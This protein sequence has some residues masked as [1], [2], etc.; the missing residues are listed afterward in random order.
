MSTHPAGTLTAVD[1]DRT[2]IY[3]AAALGLDL[4]DA[5]APRLMCVEVYRGAPLS[6]VTERAADLLSRLAE[7]TLLVP[8]TT[9]TPEQFARVHL[10][11]L[12]PEPTRGPGVAGP[13]TRYAITSNGGQVLVDG[14]PD[15][16]WDR[17]VAD[18]L[19]E[20]SPLSRLHRHLRQVSDDTFVDSI[21]VASDLFVY[22]VIRRE[23]LPVGWVDDLTEFA[24]E[25][26]W[27]MSVQGR[28]VYLVPSALTK[29]A[30]VAE[31]QR[32]T[33]AGQVVAA[34]DSL[35]DQELLEAADLGVR[36]A[37]GELAAA[38][39]SAPHVHPITVPGVLGGERLVEWLLA[40]A[41]DS[42]P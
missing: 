20:C 15:P 29:S 8:V 13:G 37:G 17:H 41:T 26:G 30:A 42:S 2:V 19:A 35:L 36:P 18:V 33:G 40:R 21:R 28:K 10:P 3:S 6:Y 38:S 27:R 32:R 4:P 7:A 31:V 24:G 14:V 12:W 22:A 25:H 23:R 1:L 11:G 39:W 34:G 16:A 9:R 5:Q